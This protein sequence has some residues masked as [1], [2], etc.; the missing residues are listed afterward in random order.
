[1][2]IAACHHDGETRCRDE[3]LC[4]TRQLLKRRFSTAVNKT[5]TTTTTH[6]FVVAPAMSKPLLVADAS[7]N[8]PEILDSSNGTRIVAERGFKIWV[9]PEGSKEFNLKN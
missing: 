1:M 5:R 7:A 4:A 8:D 3:P 2:H 6:P 9:R